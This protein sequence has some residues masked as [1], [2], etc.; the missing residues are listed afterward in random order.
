[1]E[2]YL[3]LFNGREYYINNRYT[4]NQDTHQVY[5]TYWNK[6]LVPFYNNPRS[7]N[8]YLSIN[9]TLFNHKHI[10]KWNTDPTIDRSTLR[11]AGNVP[12]ICRVCKKE[13]VKFSGKKILICN[14]CVITY[15][16]KT[17]SNKVITDTE[18]F[19][20]ADKYLRKLKAKKWMATVLDLYELID[21]YERY[22][23]NM[24]LGSPLTEE[25]ASKILFRIVRHHN[26]LK[27]ESVKKLLK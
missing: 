25:H 26:K 5:S 27:V 4:F 19:N 10:I 3:I 22:F 14:D 16:S 23:P 11:T 8:L 7:K 15:K 1:M 12:K 24:I 9:S 6:Y 20:I 13:N 17:P 21:I 2:D 18:D